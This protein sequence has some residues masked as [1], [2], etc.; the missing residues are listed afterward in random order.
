M[1][2]ISVERVGATRPKKGIKVV[3]L[4]QK[5]SLS[6]KKKQGWGKMGPVMMLLT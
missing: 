5:R 3:D 1:E 4:A 6:K 2:T